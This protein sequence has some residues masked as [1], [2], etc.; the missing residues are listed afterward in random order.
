MLGREVA[1]IVS[2]EMPAG[3]Y[4]RQWNAAKMPSGVYLYHLFAVPSAR[5]DIVPSDT[6]DR[7]AGSFTETKKMILLR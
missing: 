6:R 3:S 4:S 7:Q 2:E 1:T 5:R